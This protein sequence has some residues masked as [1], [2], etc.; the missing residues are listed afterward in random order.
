MIQLGPKEASLMGYLV[1]FNTED[2]QTLGGSLKLIWVE[3]N[4]PLCKV[5]NASIYTSLENKRMRPTV[6]KSPR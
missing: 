5:G 2:R 1:Q 6:W 4:A 3:W